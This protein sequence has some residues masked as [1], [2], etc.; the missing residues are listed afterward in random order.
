[1]TEADVARLEQAI[2][3]LRATNDE[4]HA[5]IESSINEARAEVK[6]INGEGTMAGRL[7][8]AKFEGAIGGGRFVWMIM[9]AIPPSILAIVAILEKW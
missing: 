1:M 9:G 3:D 4:A 7:W 2:A 5:R 8:R 6:R